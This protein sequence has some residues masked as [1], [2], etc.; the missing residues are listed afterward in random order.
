MQSCFVDE[1]ESAL[2]NAGKHTL[3][4]ERECR[5]WEEGEGDP[6]QVGLSAELAV[7]A[8]QGALTALGDDGLAA[9]GGDHQS[10]RGRLACAAWLLLL[11]GTD[12]EGTS[13]DLQQAGTLFLK[14]ADA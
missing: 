3:R 2:R 8:A 4:A 6:D 5:R 10:R 9:A 12:E 13:D 14:A 7:R 1:T 11:M